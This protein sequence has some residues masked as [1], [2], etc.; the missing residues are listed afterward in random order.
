MKSGRS[1]CY[2]F[3]AEINFPRIQLEWEKR[4]VVALPLLEANFNAR[5]ETG[6]YYLT[7]FGMPTGHTVALHTAPCRRMTTLTL[8][9][10]WSRVVPYQLL[11]H[12]TTTTV[13][14]LFN[15]QKMNT[16]LSKLIFSHRFET[17]EFYLYENKTLQL[18]KIEFGVIVY[19]RFSYFHPSIFV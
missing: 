6:D 11:V 9:P 13:F 12:Y 18:Y 10:V 15:K 14:N 3:S 19:R 8:T 1:C 17:C 7:C 4:R 5:C 2:C 16:L